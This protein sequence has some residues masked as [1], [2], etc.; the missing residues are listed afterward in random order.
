LAQLGQGTLILALA[1]S[2]FGI[3]L[4]V[5]GERRRMPQLTDAGVRALIGVAL[6][7]SIA[8]LVLLTAFVTHDFSLAYVSGRSSSDMPLYF[9]ISAF[10]GGQEGSLLFW[11]WVVSVIGAAAFYRSRNRFPTL[12]PYATATLLATIGFLLFVLAFV[13]TPFSVNEIAPSE[14]RGL[15]PLLRDPGMLVHPPMLL[16]GFATLAIPFAITVSAL[17]TGQM[18]TDWLRFVRRWAL[19]SWAVLSAGLFLG[20]WWAYHVL[21]WGGYWAW[22][23]VE[24]V[25]LLPWLTLTAFVHSVMVQERRGMLKT[26]NVGLLLA[27]FLLS[28][29]GTFIVRSGLISSVHAFALSDIGPYFLSFLAVMVVGSTALL[30]WRLPLLKAEN[31]FESVWSRE[32]G[33]LLNNLVFTGI[34]FATLWGTI[35]PLIT[36]LF[37]G[38]AITVGAPFYNQVNGPL[39]VLLLALMGLGPLLA[40]RR[41]IMSSVM[42]SIAVPLTIT[43][44][45]LAGVLFLYGQPPA[46]IGAAAAVF[47]ICAV[48]VEYVRGVKLRRKNAGDNVPTAIYRLTRRDPRRFGGYIV[49]LGVA[50]IAIGIVGSWFFSTERQVVVTPGQAVDVAGYTVTYQRLTETRTSDSR[51]ITAYVNV[52][53]GNTDHGSVGAKRFTYRGFEDQMT[54]QVAI[55]TVGFDDVYIMLLEWGADSE[56]HL[57]IFVNPLVTWIWAGGAVYLLGMLILFL[58]APAIAPV[59]VRAASRRDAFGEVSAD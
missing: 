7:V 46:A 39:L 59:T 41:T 11:T 52:S 23:P 15:N 21:G 33:F 13:A 14:G 8:A 1:L 57:R 42:R 17:I 53:S 4:C 5:Y 55:N 16:T 37:R 29:F 58:P 50:I 32:S 27:S 24:N 25:A 35:Y 34:A 26:W 10:Y 31:T 44:C 43:V 45:V 56:A 30:I 22:D 12:V 36:E 18:T 54:T 40:W 9:V 48:I 20:G 3:G 28:I 47:A 49:H 19:V 6:L 51:I 2:I 38:T